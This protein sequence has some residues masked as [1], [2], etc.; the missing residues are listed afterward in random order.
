VLAA[1]QPIVQI[2]HMIK[3]LQF[4]LVVYAALLIQVA[5]LPV[6][7]ADPFQPNLLIIIVVYLGLRVGG[8]HGGVLAFLLGLLDDSFSGIYL[9]LSAFSF[10]AIYM[11][12]RNVSGRLYTDSLL[13]TLMVV[14]LA[15]IANG[16]L[17][18]LLLLLFS[19]ASGIYRSLLPALIPQ[20]LVNAFAAS[21]VFSLP[22]LY[23]REETR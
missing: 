2:E 14:V 9:G 3:Y 20:A 8:W 19:A 21:L 15:T 7:L 11:A 13:L 22:R 23:S 12:M 10:L 16:L 5:V 17:H 18:L 4:I 1:L 6:Y